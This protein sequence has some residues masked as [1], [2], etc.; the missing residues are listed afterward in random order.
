MHFFLGALRVNVHFTNY[1]PLSI[2]GQLLVTWYNA[3]YKQHYLFNFHFLFKKNLMV[4]MRYNNIL[5][6]RPLNTHLYYFSL[7]FGPA[8]VHC[9]SDPIIN[10]STGA[11]LDNLVDALV[12]E[13]DHNGDGNLD[14]DEVR[15]GLLGQFAGPGKYKPFLS[16]ADFFS[17]QLF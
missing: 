4:T 1:S 3:K 9:D 13:M 6:S 11:T 12:K 5:S 14:I 10:F 16:S 17:N 15:D 7:F 8:T 2:I